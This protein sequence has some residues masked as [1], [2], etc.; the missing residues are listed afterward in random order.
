VL[1]DGF[2]EWAGGRPHWITRA[3]GKPFA[4]AGLWASWRPAEDVEALRSCSIV[5]VAATE[6]L[7]ALHDRMPVILRTEDEAAWLG[8]DTPAPVLHGLLR[9]FGDTTAREVG[10]AVND[11]RHDAPDCLAAPEPTLF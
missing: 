4:F 3:D 1:A 9:G 5:T 11:A 6:R 10:R 2:F 7:R 8:R